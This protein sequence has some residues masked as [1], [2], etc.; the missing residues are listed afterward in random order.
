MDPT[1]PSSIL[2]PV[3]GRGVPVIQPT[4]PTCILDD[5]TKLA[6]SNTAFEALLRDRTII[7]VYLMNMYR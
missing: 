6:I 2:S 4:Y 7:D 1:T 3:L 5:S